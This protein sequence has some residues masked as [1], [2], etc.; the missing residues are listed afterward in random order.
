MDTTNNEGVRIG[1]WG[2]MGVGLVATAIPGLFNPE[3]IMFI[4]GTIICTAGI[5]LV[6]WIPFWMLIGMILCY[7][8]RFVVESWT[9]G[10]IN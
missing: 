6:L 10:K 7:L 2:Y 5:S 1:K 9:T 3:Y 4:L 8:Y